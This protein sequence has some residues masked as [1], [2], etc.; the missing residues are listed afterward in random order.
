M[1]PAVFQ[2]MKGTVY[3]PHNGS[4][5]I[6]IKSSRVRIAGRMNNIVS[7]YVKI[8]GLHEVI[9]GKM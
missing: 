3:I 5:R 9:A 4:G 2:E 6:A 8:D 7:L 1:R